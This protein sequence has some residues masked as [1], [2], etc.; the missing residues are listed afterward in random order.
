MGEISDHRDG[1][2]GDD[3]VVGWSCVVMAVCV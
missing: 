2:E 3:A 1:R